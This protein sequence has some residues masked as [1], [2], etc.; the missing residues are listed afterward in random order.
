MTAATAV[1][2]TRVEELAALFVRFLETNTAPDG[3]FTD[4]VFLDLSLP[5]WRLQA[6]GREEFVALR[7]R[8]HPCRGTVPRHR[9]DPTPS[10]FVL[11]FEENWTDAQGTWYCREL[12]RADLRDGAIAE[13]SVYCTGDWDPATRAAHAEKVRLLRP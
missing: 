11:E 13:A 5:Q 7:R 6:R 9:A 12:M 8:S 3:L 4:D 10:G 1:T 2:D